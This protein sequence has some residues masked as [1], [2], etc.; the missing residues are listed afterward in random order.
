MPE[1]ELVRATL[2]E[3]VEL[4]LVR[5]AEGVRTL[6]LGSATLG[7]RLAWTDPITHA[8]FSPDGRLLALAS[9]ERLATFSRVHDQALMRIESGP[10]A[11][12]AFRQD[13]RVLFVGV[14]RPL[15]ELALDPRSGELVLAAQ[16]DTDAFSR[17]EAAELDPSWRWAIEDEGSFLRT[18]DGQA[19]HIRNDDA[20]LESGWMV[21]D[22]PWPEFGMRF[23]PHSLAPLVSAPTLA[24]ALAR[25]NLIAEF[26]DGAPLPRAH[27]R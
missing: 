19:L 27:R 16:L 4:V 8:A 17:I 7:P 14:E 10:I 22:D 23:G 12:L 13:S 15:P 20:L 25:P 21:G 3:E 9:D 5:D 11:G 1:L 2:D 6:D 18:L 24:A 26:F